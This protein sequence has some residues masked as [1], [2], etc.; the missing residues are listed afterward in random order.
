MNKYKIVIKHIG[1]NKNQS[2]I[3]NDINLELSPQSKSVIAGKSGSGKTSLLRLI[4]RLEEPTEGSIYY[5]GVNIIDINV[6][7]LRKKVTLVSQIPI[8]LDYTVQDN[9]TVQSKLGITP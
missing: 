1:L 8:V 6:L 2:V 7:E 5:D 9:L 4:N 3:F